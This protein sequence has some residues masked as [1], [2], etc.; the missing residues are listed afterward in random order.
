MKV[1]KPKSLDL[2]AMQEELELAT[3]QMKKAT[4]DLQKSNIAY[5]EAEE[6]YNQANKALINGVNVLR[7]TT[8]MNP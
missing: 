4:N 6:R 8:K 5:V 7:S 1:L 3:K 2:G